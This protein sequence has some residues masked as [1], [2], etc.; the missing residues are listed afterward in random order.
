M[1][2]DVLRVL[3]A[4]ELQTLKCLENEVPT[5]V[6]HYER[7]PYGKGWGEGSSFLIATRLL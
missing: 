6:K 7:E 1:A 2:S 5:G 3:T 4:L